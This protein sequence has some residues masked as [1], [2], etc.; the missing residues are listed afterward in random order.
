MALS[1][2]VTQN[3]MNGQRGEHLVAERSM[4]MGM[5]F[6][7][8]NRLEAGVDGFIELRD[9][10][11]RQMLARWIGVQVKTTADGSY[12]SEDETGFSYLLKPED[13]E[14]WRASNIPVIIVLVR[15][16]DNSMYWKPVGDGLPTE[17]RRLVFNKA[18]D[19]FDV[20]A[21]DAIAALCIDRHRLGSH[22]PPMQSGEPMHLTMLRVVLPDEIYVGESLYASGRDAVRALSE[23]EVQA[24]YEWVVRKRRFLSFRDPNTTGLTEIVEEGTVE[25]VE[26]ELVATTEDVDDQNMF[27]ELLSRTLSAQLERD[28]AFDRETRALFFKA[29]AENT[30]R[31]YR[32]RSMVNDTAAE[33]VSVFRRKDGAIGSV[34]HHAFVPRFLPIGGEWYVAVEPT[35]VFTRDGYRAHY[36]AGE[37]LAGK[38]KFERNGSIRGQFL[39]WSHL[40]VASGSDAAD[41]LSKSSKSILKFEPVPA[42]EMPLA[43]PEEA[44]TR[45][46]PNAAK[47]AIQEAML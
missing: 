15:L 11:T 38:K 41:L 25:A 47:L 13:L 6:D 44:W 29:T 16:S 43:V 39:M 19:K 18:A 34:R 8:R 28:L 20:S 46:D 37:L 2:V 24:H 30:G 42:L 33:V 17:P 4:A 36:N 45:E 31:R 12:T 22:V 23:A 1:K 10:A 35:F 3:Q 14:Y 26:T 5:N 27:I 32:Y 40:L 9:P 7:G 21:A